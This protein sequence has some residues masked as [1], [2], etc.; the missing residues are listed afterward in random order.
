MATTASNGGMYVDKKPERSK[1]AFDHHRDPTT[2]NNPYR[3][4]ML[5][6]GVLPHP[7]TSD[8]L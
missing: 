1:T 5:Q 7:L 6:L 2:V 4:K 3:P 8:S